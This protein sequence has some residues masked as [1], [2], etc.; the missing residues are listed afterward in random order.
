MISSDAEPEAVDLTR[1]HLES[2]SACSDYFQGLQ[3]DAQALAK[4]AEAH[5]R[6]VEHLKRRTIANLAR[7]SVRPHSRNSRLWRIVVRRPRRTAAVAAVLTA[8]LLVVFLRGPESSFDAWAEVVDSI[9]NASSAQFRLRKVD[10]GN[11]E[12]R[13]I[14]S[15]RGTCHLTFEDGELVEAMYVDFDRRSLLYMAYPLRM[16]A[17]MSIDPSIA[18]SFRSHDPARTFDFLREYEYED[19]GRR[20]IDGHQ[21]VGI[22]ITDARFLAERMERAEL[23]LWVDPASKLPI[24]FD[25]IGDVAGDSRK[26]HVRFYDFRWNEP[27]AEDVFHPEIPADFDVHA[28]TELRIDE[29]HFLEGLRL[30]ADVV[31]RYPTS[32]AY[33]SVKI[34]L[35]RSPGARVR[36][37]G[38]MVLRMFQ[39]RLASDF[40]GELVKEESGVVYYGHDVKPEDAHR[41]LVRWRI[42]EESYRV[43]FG[44]L[45]VETVDPARLIDLEERR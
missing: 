40:Y 6:H 22:R 9:R 10:G 23:E 12:A 3:E 30:F 35:W 42:D 2:C 33:E 1:A 36:S 18:D 29:E 39:I 25:V 44:N 31:G 5:A 7:S 13:Q 37:V 16:A 19:L 20:S 11:V 24:R 43:V 34:E 17:R 38:P 4:L 41:I 26:R 8:A 28:G 21:A 45:D 14:Y 15:Q 32:L 27:L